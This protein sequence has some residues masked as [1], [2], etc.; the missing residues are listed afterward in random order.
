MPATQAV[1]LLER[2]VT[3]AG[4]RVSARLERCCMETESCSAVQLSARL[5]D[6]LPSLTTWLTRQAAPLCDQQPRDSCVECKKMA[7]LVV[8]NL[9]EQAPDLVTYLMYAAC[10]EEQSS[11]GSA[12]CQA[13]VQQHWT[14]MA[15]V[16]YRDL[17]QAACLYRG[18]CGLQPGPHYCTETAQLL[19]GSLARR[20]GQQAAQLALLTQFCPSQPSS[21]NSTI[22]S[23]VQPLT[24]AAAQWI[25]DNH[26]NLCFS[27][28]AVWHSI[29]SVLLLLS[30][31]VSFRL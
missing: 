12:T 8:E 25:I 1:S 10:Q 23:L 21:C 27:R 4:P 5:P 24:T 30:L 22:T 13:Y 6:L 31:A 2:S 20:S 18:A 26:Y 28:A 11:L 17:G 7:E 29:S 15:E 19:A 3:D 9:T 16:M 14:D